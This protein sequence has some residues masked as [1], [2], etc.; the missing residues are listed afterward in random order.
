MRFA[1]F[2]KATVILAVASWGTSFAQPIETVAEDRFQEVEK[3]ALLIT[4][5]HYSPLKPVANATADGEALAGVLRPLGFRVRTLPEPE[6]SN[7]ILFALN[8]INQ[9]AKSLAR[10]SVVF[11]YFAGH[12]FQSAGGKNHL[13]PLLARADTLGDDSVPVRD[14]VERIAPSAHGFGVVLIDACRTPH[15]LARDHQPWF[16][17]M[18]SGRRVLLGLSTKFGDVAQSVSS[19]NPGQSPYSYG[20]QRR[21]AQSQISIDKVLDAVSADVE[22]DTRGAQSPI[23]VKS[24]GASSS[25]FYINVG[26]RPRERQRRILESIVKH[27]KSKYCLERFLA[28]FPAGPLSIAAAEL[29]HF[30]SDSSTGKCNEIFDADQFD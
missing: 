4:V 21:L 8:E 9:L 22:D 5:E 26:Q 16:S 24:A 23:V 27:D 28:S 3:F 13:V 6:D 30:A 12:G 7:Q 15:M 25:G 19:A 29:T 18:D 20:L 2:A 1:L 10:P 14:L 11:V 17:P